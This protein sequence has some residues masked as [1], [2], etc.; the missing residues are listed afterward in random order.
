M[1]NQYEVLSPWAEV[2]PIPLKGITPRLTDI[3]GKK[4][5]MFCNSKAAS[6]PTLAIVARKLKER[7]PTTEL[8]WYA[9]TETFT[10]LQMVGNDK[11]RFIT[12]VKS[13]DAVIGAIGD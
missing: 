10:T 7:F 13:V 11:D 8:S 6:K 12:W 9:A 4:I 1:N 3:N 2:D 5:G